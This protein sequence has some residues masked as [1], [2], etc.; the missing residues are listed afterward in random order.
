MFKALIIFSVF[1]AA[2]VF[3]VFQVIVP[4]F[5]SK[6][7]VM[8]SF[9]K[10]KPPVTD[11]DYLERNVDVAI[12]NFDKAANDVADVD[13]KVSQIAEKLGSIKEKTK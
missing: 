7:P 11:L 8:W 5:S 2:A 9:R 3:L 6:I 4:L 10:S 12:E 1:L 13:D